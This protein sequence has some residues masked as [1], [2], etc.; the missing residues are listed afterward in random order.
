MTDRLFLRNKGED[1]RDRTNDARV[2]GCDQHGNYRVSLDSR[3][4]PLPY[5]PEN[6]AFVSTENVPFDGTVLFAQGAQQYYAIK[7]NRLSSQ[8]SAFGI[9]FEVISTASNGGTYAKLYLPSEIEQKELAS[10]S[11]VFRYLQLVAE[12][13]KPNI[14]DED[15][16]EYL[17]RQ[18]KRIQFLEGTPAD[19]MAH[20]EKAARP[21]M[22]PE[23]IIYPFGSNLSQMKAVDKALSNQL[24]LIEGPPG[25]GKTQTILNIIANLVMQDKTIL[26]TSP[27]NEA[28]KNVVEKLKDEGFR[29]IAAP[30]GRRK[31]TEAFVANQEEAY[32]AALRQWSLSKEEQAALR[33]SISANTIVAR[34]MYSHKNRLAQQEARL[35]DLE[36]E[37]ARFIDSNDTRSLGR[38]RRSTP[39]RIRAARD[40]VGILSSEENEL[41]LVDKMRIV[42]V[43]GIGSWRDFNHLNVDTE[44]NLNRM[45]FEVQI[46]E[47]N[48]SIASHQAYLETHKSEGLIEDI[49]AASRRLLE[50]KLYDHYA[51]RLQRG[52]RH[53][54]NPWNEPAK[55]REEYPLITST[56]NAARNQIGKNGELFDYVIIDESSQ[57]N[58]VTGFLALAAAQN[59]VVVGDTKQLPCVLDKR[60]EK[61]ARPLFRPSRLPQRYNFVNNSL[62]DCLNACIDQA[63]LQA[64]RTLLR[65]HYRCHPEIIGFLQSAILRRRT[66]HHVWNLRPRSRRCALVQYQQ[67]PELRS[68]S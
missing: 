21:N 58:L 52:R 24:S 8:N 49:T 61:Q 9:R 26:V 63:G 27:N 1:F 30:L 3:S 19:R 18:F 37:Y 67:E 10:T 7:L 31:N 14:T 42:W 57:A 29:F 16:R 41:S 68:P 47:C 51:S 25:T 5:N 33:E 45:L 48:A 32:P 56:T 20:P 53:F 22:P 62:L 15:K 17:P 60:E 65:E 55:F 12:A 6:V 35:K 4:K 28:T 23:T 13:T 43:G 34:G 54:D 50:A 2:G 59:A 64:P 44:I 39:E 40:L 11:S 38:K 36:L 46:E 66:H